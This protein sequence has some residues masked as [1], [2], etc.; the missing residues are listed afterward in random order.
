[1]LLFE[2]MFE[3]MFP[4]E[5]EFEFM[6]PFRFLF[7]FPVLFEFMLL[8]L[9]FDMLPLLMLPVDVLLLLVVVVLLE[10]PLEFLFPQSF[11]KMESASRSRTTM[12]CFIEFSPMVE[13]KSPRNYG[14]MRGKRY[15]PEARKVCTNTN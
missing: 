15:S 7:L 2:F 1:M 5:F 11:A 14:G 8:A 4:F 10:L 6:F 3:F 12:P 9:P 13:D